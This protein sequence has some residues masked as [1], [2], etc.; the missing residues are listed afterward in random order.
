MLSLRLCCEFVAFGEGIRA[1][2]AYFC[3]SQLQELLYM[4]LSH[5]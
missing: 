5:P 3:V 2:Y 4:F 1:I